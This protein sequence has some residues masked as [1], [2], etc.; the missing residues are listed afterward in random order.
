MS[1]KKKTK[2][3]MSPEKATAEGFA[4]ASLGLRILN[5]DPRS[6]VFFRS[7][8]VKRDVGQFVLIL[9]AQWQQDGVIQFKRL[10]DL[11]SLG[12]VIQSMIDEAAWKPDKYG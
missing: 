1:N 9:R 7:F 11:F 4:M 3:G 8:T 5:Q 2:T 10:D 6:D 12:A